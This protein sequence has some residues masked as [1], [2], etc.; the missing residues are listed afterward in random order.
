MA[1]AVAIISI[2][3]GAAA[4]ASGCG[5]TAT[6]LRDI[7]QRYR[8]T[9]PMIASMAQELATTQCAWDLV[10]NMLDDWRCQGA[11]DE[12]LLSTLTES[13]QAGNL[14]IS[15]LNDELSSCTSPSAVARKS[16]FRQR[17][18]TIWNEKSLR[19]CQ[20]RIRGQV[21]SL[22]LLISVLRM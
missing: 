3:N 14:I 17:T 13:L 12:D 19:A 4:L 6:W 2:I 9:G 20:E 11:I 10:Q 8:Q 22:S 15:S 1:E 5:R 7:A 18:K 21:I 16:G